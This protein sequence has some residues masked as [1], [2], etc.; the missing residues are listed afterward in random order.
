[1]SHLV[2]QIEFIATADRLKSVLRKTSPIGLERF[3]NS[4]EHS[5]QVMLA[6]IVLNEYSNESVD[7][8]RV[9]RMLAIHDLHEIVL[10]DTLHQ[11]KV[12]LLGAQSDEVDAART[13]FS[14]L[15]EEQREEFI[16]LWLEFEQRETAEAKFAA[17]LDRLMAFIL[18]LRNEGGSWV[19]LNISADLAFEENA[20][21]HEGSEAIWNYV[22]NVI[23]DGRQKGYLK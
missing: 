9:I 20:H 14:A 8:L 12:S 7:L 2:Q 6:A 4:G 21:I 19:K 22:K 10:G 16:G 13:V 18:N 1:M 17:S 15:L 23:T 5:W 11:S 3:E